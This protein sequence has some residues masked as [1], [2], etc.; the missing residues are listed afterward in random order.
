MEVKF[1]L[2]TVHGLDVP[3]QTV[4]HYMDDE[5]REEIH[6]EMAPCEAQAFCDEYA[7]RHM[8]K[9]GQEWIIN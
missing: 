4:V 9:Y 1:E 2:V 6:A 5:L 3:M 8:E 7:R